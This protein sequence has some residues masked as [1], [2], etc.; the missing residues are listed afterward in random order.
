M[1][2][3]QTLQDG[4][5]YEIEQK[6][7]RGIAKFYLNLQLFYADIGNRLFNGLKAIAPSR[8]I[9]AGIAESNMASMAAGAAKFR[10]QDSTGIRADADIRR[11]WHGHRRGLYPD[12]Q[13]AADRDHATG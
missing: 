12:L 9:N 6:Y 1:K 10:G 2:Q 8:T 4:L 3:L 13:R 7:D 5:H 11:A